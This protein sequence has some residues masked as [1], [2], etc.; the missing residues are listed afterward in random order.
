VVGRTTVDWR[1]IVMI[2]VV[3]VFFGIVRLNI[4]RELA[5]LLLALGGYWAVMA[6]LQ[7]WRQ[8]GALLGSPKVTYW[9]GQRIELPARGSTARRARF[10]T[11]GG[12]A[13]IVSVIYLGL[14]I[15]CWYAAVRLALFLFT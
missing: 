1:W 11:P 12:T 5:V 3:L 8:P 4:P 15:G 7:P 10:R 9:R 13:L 2:L 14:G 6:G